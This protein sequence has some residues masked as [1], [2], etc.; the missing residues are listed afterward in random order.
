MKRMKNFWFRKPTHPF[1][2]GQWWSIFRI[3]CLHMRQWWARSYFSKLHFVQNLWSPF[4]FT[5]T[6]TSTFSTGIILCLVSSSMKLDDVAG[7]PTG[8][9]GE[10][11]RSEDVSVAVGRF[12]IKPSSL[13]FWTSVWIKWE[14]SPTLVV[15]ESSCDRTEF[16]N[17]GVPPLPPP[18]AR[19]AQSAGVPGCVASIWM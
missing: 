11:C 7:D 16:W 13:T 19:T 18:P 6:L 8:T 4:L 5:V 3:H 12:R 9:T 17:P 2:H 10:F 14:P 15:C 1:I